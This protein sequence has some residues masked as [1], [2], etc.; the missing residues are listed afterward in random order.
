MKIL[1]LFGFLL[2]CGVESYIVTTRR[3]LAIKMAMRGRVRYSVDF[4]GFAVVIVIL[5]AQYWVLTGFISIYLLLLLLVASG[6]GLLAH[7]LIGAISGFDVPEKREKLLA[8]SVIWSA[9]RYKYGC[10]VLLLGLITGLF[11]IVGSLYIFFHYEYGHP[12]AQFLIAT[13]IFTL[14]HA[15][16]I[17]ASTFAALPIV[18]SSYTDDDFRNYRLSFE[19]SSVVYRTI[20]LLFPF[21]AFPDE[22]MKFLG[23]LPPLWILL[24]IP[25]LFFVLGSIFPFF[26][27]LHRHRKQAYEMLDWR[28]RWLGEF[29]AVLNL[30]DGKIR[31]DSLDEKFGQLEEEIKRKFAG[32]ELFHF[33]QKHTVPDFSHK[34]WFL[35][36]RLMPLDDDSEPDSGVDLLAD[37]DEILDE[38]TTREA[39]KNAKKVLRIR[40]RFSFFPDQMQKHM[41]TQTTEYIKNINIIIERYKERLVEWDIRFNHLWNLA[42][43]YELSLEVKRGDIRDFINNRLTTLNDSMS[44]E[45]KRKNVISAA[46]LI[47]LSSGGALF[48]REFQD[49]ILNIVS[50]LVKID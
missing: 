23:P 50:E 17:V 31:S 25:L 12:E 47:V 7:N 39:I 37:G 16:G 13:F 19:F 26:V 29:L 10:G 32:N 14:N 28:R 9:Q 41:G 20:L 33:F 4:L 1:A 30:P 34:E 40:E 38:P 35:P 46:I 6:V 43:V 11:V 15:F 45:S 2:L 49:Q 42:D 48:V 18:T 8:L 3:N 5:F 21:L 27:G 22:A 44:R 24:S 36:P